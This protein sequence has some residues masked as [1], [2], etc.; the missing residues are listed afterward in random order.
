MSLH[1]DDRHLHQRSLELAAMSVDF[2]LTRAEM[3]E[4]EAHLAACPS[5]DRRVAAL[6]TDARALGQPFEL[7]PSSSVDAAVY[8]AIARRSAP[9]QRLLLMAAAALLLLGA[10]AAGAVGASL[11]HD[12]QTLPTT[13]VPTA[14][15][16][17]ASPGLDT[18]PAALGET[19]QTLDFPAY[20]AGGLIEA[21]AFDGVDFVG[22][23]RGGCVPDFNDPTNC[24]GAA[25]TMAPDGAWVRT[26]DQPGLEVGLTVPTSGPE[27]GIFDVAM[28]PAGL[29]AIGQA[30]DDIGSGVWRSPDGKTWERFADVLGPRPSS[31]RLSAIAAGAGGYVIVGW[32]IDGYM[33]GNAA[34]P[35][36]HAAA[37]ASPDGVTWTRAKDSADM[38]VGP[39]FDTTEEP[40]CGGMLGVTPS[41]SGFVAVG[42]NRTG[43]AANATRPAA[44]TSPDG[45]AWTRSD[46]GLDFDGFLSGVTPG[47]PGLVAIGTICQSEC[48][49][50]AAGGI[51]VTSV[52][53][54]TWSVVPVSGAIPLDHV[55][56]TGDEVFA[57][58]DANGSELQLWRSYTG[59]TW[60]RATGM[61]SP[62]GA[63]GYRGLD[64]AATADRI[65]VVGW[66]NVGG[67]GEPFR[68]FAYMSPAIGSAAPT[69]TP[70]PSEPVATEVDPAVLLR[71]EVR[72]DVSAGRWPLMTVY[73]DGTVLRRADPDGLVTRLTPAGLELLLAPATDSGLFAKSGDI[74]DALGYDA[75]FE[76][77]TIDL[78]QGET[79]VRRS[80]TNVPKST[81]T[82]AEAEQIIALAEHL[83]SLG[84]WLPADAWNVGPASATPYI[85][86]HYLLKI[87]VVK[88]RPGVN[89]A[90]WPL[91]VAD[92]D[93]PLAGGLDTFGNPQE[94][95]PLG[96]GST[97]RCGVLTLAEAAAVQRVLKDAPLVPENRESLQ[98]DLSW[99]AA[100]SQVTVK[101]V[102]L[103]P[104]DPLDCAVDVNWP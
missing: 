60:Q 101:L 4:L 68:N 77:Y 97:S 19:W 89:D 32:M 72:P 18:V 11:L 1:L 78:R 15:V 25:W 22:V 28:G 16:A 36:A 37:W 73:S 43:P 92:L 23:G 80:T 86:S 58:G 33:P 57:L 62:E 98:A 88:D 29:V 93:W 26:P 42:Q 85:P 7:L 38:D 94:P 24:Y 100:G 52:D 91:D 13:D 6:R 14:P 20:S 49:G 79:M 47:G 56:A 44:W 103:L 12:R 90:T 21:V 69:P 27:K 82:R 53:G 102:P 81:A 40:S 9:P 3:G 95:P 87:T 30:Y 84:S 48:Y 54:S 63:G 83:D 99:K 31:M 104:D 59:V 10:L 45:L 35:T 41:G 61:P 8:A 50:T 64:I 65:V 55:A 67:E 96:A 17:D 76:T 2:D 75:G 70:S 5:C 39:C 74:R 51:A 66:A 34:G 46:G 71:V